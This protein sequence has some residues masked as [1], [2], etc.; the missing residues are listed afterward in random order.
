M[1]EETSYRESHKA[2][3]PDYHATFEDLPHRKMIW[4]FERNVLSDIVATEFPNDRPSHLDF[5]SGTGRILAHLSPLAASSTAVDVSESMLDVARR[6]VPA[7]RFIL[8]DITRDSLLVDE[9]FDLITAFRFFPNAEP[10]L[11][12]DVIH[13]L[14]ERLSENG[15]LVFN[16]HM[17]SK[18]LLHRLSSIR[19]GADYSDSGMTESGVQ[20]LVASAGLKILRRHPIAIAPVSENHMKFPKFTYA[21]ETVLRKL[22]GAAAVAQNVIYVCALDD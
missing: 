3:G 1:S 9:R 14:R 10:E 5:A 6:N 4:K 22:P 8:G 13:Q 12:S 17:N 18:S 11:R 2:K 16:N 19:R 7:A 21:L 15:R 20:E